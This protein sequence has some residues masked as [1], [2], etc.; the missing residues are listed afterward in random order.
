MASSWVLQRLSALLDMVR[1]PR[2]KA[3]RAQNLRPSITFSS[4]PDLI[5]L[6][7]RRL[8]SQQPN[9]G[10]VTLNG[11]VDD[12]AEAKRDI[13][14]SKPGKLSADGLV[15]HAQDVTDATAATLRAPL[16]RMSRRTP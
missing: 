13:P 5:P 9:A 1:C 16:P 7:M 15:L 3:A 12:G 11:Y 8:V 14:A 2:L 10:K 6:A 4:K